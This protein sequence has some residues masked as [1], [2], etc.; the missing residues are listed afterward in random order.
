MGAAIVIGEQPLF[1]VLSA[2]V[3]PPLSTG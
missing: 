3:A 1:A 2:P